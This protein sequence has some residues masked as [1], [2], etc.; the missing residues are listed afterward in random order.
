MTR[1]NEKPF[2]FYERDKNKGKT[3]KED[4]NIKP[5]QFKANEVPWFC[6]VELYE[7]EMAKAEQLRKERINRRA[8]TVRVL[9]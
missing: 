3:F 2:S 5:K 7:Q 1:A 6:S 9:A 4:Y 8:Q